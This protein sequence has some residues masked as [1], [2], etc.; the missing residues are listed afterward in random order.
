MSLTL[1]CVFSSNPCRACTVPLFR[2]ALESQK[3][4]CFLFHLFIKK[5]EIKKKMR[6]G[7]DACKEDGRKHCLQIQAQELRHALAKRY[8]RAFFLYF[9]I[10]IEAI[11]NCWSN[12]SSCWSNFFCYGQLRTAVCRQHVEPLQYRAQLFLTGFGRTLGS[13]P[14]R[15]LHESSPRSVRT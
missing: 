11:R 6:L 10:W 7:P 9:T 1:V 2:R 5:E 12:F 3:A 13:G 8:N 4:T 14:G 15:V